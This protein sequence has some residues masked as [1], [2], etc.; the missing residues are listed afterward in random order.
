MCF[1]L[2]GLR[3]QWAEFLLAGRAHAN[4]R[5]GFKQTI[6]DRFGD[7]ARFTVGAEDLRLPV[8]QRTAAAGKTSVGTGYA[9]IRSAARRVCL[10]PGIELR[11]VHRQTEQLAACIVY[12]VGV[13]SLTVRFWSEL[14][15]L[16]HDL[17]TTGARGRLRSGGLVL[18]KDALCQL[19]YA[20]ENGARG[21][22]RTRDSWFGRPALCRN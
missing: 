6:N 14:A 22:V 4:E 7:V 10:E 3:G 18:T 11:S 2:A 16:R 15:N 1:R 12:G 21:G 9:H 8:T 19:S 5:L 13:R 20:G 17:P